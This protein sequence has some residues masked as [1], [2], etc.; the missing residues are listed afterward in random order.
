ME[1]ARLA[2]IKAALR[3]LAELTL[4]QLAT[5]AQLQQSN[6]LPSI[7]SKQYIQATLNEDGVLSVKEAVRLHGG[8][9][10]AILNDYVRSDL[11][12]HRNLPIVATFIKSLQSEFISS[13]TSTL[14]SC[15]LY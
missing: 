13:A 12:Q 4:I 3:L 7:L 15:N 8:A 2:Q 1:A 6:A 9:I 10:Y 11:E 5:P 14:F